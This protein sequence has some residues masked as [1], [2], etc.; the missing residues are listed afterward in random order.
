MIKFF[1]RKKGP[2]CEEIGVVLQSY[3]DGEVDE[4]TALRVASHLEGCVGCAPEAL[5][6]SR[7]KASLAAKTYAVDPEILA[8]LQTFG[9][10]VAR[11]EFDLSED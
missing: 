2:S 1:R 5:A 10:R 7:I 3:L 4:A 6:Y 8:N 9:E 11:S